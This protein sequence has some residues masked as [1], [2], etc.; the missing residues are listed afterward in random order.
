MT[1]ASTVGAATSPARGSNWKSWRW[2]V[3][4]VVVLGLVAVVTSLLTSPR[5]GGYLDAESTTPTGAHALIALLEDAGVEVVIADTVADVEAAASPDA[6]LVIAQTY[7][8]PDGDLLDRLAGV[9]GDRLVIA[10]TSTSRAVLAPAVQR[11]E[12]TS[13]DGDPD[14]DLA[15]ALRAG[16]VQ[17]DASS[18]FKASGDV[19]VTTCY[20]RAL[21]RYSDDGRTVTTIDDGAFLTNDE[22]ATEGNAAL[23]MN[24]AGTRP[25]MIWYAPQDFEEGQQPVARDLS[26]LIPDR[27]TWIFWQLCLVVILLAIW[28]ARRI[29]PLVTEQ[30]PV[31]VRASETVEGR[32]RL[33]RARR[34]RDRASASLRTATLQRLVPR[35]GL[36]Q[37]ATPH[38]IVTAAAT[39]STVPAQQLQYLLYGPPPISDDELVALATA[40]DNIERQVAYS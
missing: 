5:P 26:E 1:G 39:R 22:L 32:G 21:A 10:P 25:A 15:E 3:A 34:A 31:V 36:G 28:Q 33:Y 4:A 20:G 27:F 12:L 30:L 35:L 2:V 9:P 8:T 7:Y 37:T 6:L 16:V 13:I 11:A 19:P 38:E 17:L 18:G 24:L 23:A 29:G 14:C 40:L